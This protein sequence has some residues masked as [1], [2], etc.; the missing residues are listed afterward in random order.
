[1]NSRLEEGPGALDTVKLLL[2]SLIL[3]GGIFA[4]YYYI[5]VSVLWRA[6]GVLVAFLAALGVVMTTYQGHLLSQFI[7]GARIELRKVVWPS[8][9]EYI[10]TTVIV[11]VFALIGG[12]FF[13]LLDLFLLSVRQYIVG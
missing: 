7:S 10:Q 6:I 2:A 3:V 11:L 1:M 5:D 4:Y 13:W 8:R 12:V 9:E